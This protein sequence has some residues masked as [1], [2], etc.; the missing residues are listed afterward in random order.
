MKEEFY[1]LAVTD[2]GTLCVDRW[3]STDQKNWLIQRIAVT[4]ED[5][6]FVDYC[7]EE[8][9]R[10]QPGGYLLWDWE[11][12]DRGNELFKLSHGGDGLTRTEKI[13]AEGKATGEVGCGLGKQVT[14]AMPKIEWD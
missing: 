11:K 2:S 14:K 4:S 7:K 10:H 5:K 3:Q 12:D 13:L 6:D 1:V 8:C 9:L